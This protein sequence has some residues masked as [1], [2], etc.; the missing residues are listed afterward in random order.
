MAEEERRPLLN[1][2]LRLLVEPT[3]EPAPGGGKSRTTTKVERLEQQMAKLLRQVTSLHEARSTLA[4]HGTRTALL[5]R[6]FASDSLAPSH[7]PT[8]LFSDDVGCRLVAPTGDGYIVEA[9]VARLPELAERIRRA[10][11][12]AIR[13]DI[14][15]VR[16]IRRFDRSGVLRGRSVEELWNRAVEADGGRYFLVWLRPYHDPGAREAL[17]SAFD[18]L[19]RE[20]T[21]LPSADAGPLF[22][23]GPP[24]AI[25]STSTARAMRE[26]RR[27]RG[28][29]RAVVRV[30]DRA[31]LRRILASGTVFRMDP[32]RPVRASAGRGGTP[33]LPVP[34]LP[35]GPVVA[36]VDG[37]LH[38]LAYKA[39]ESWRVAPIVSDTDADRVHGNAVVSLVAHAHELN[40]H[41][42]LPR[43]GT[44]VGT[45]Q[46][47][48]HRESNVLLLPDD[49][50]DML[51]RMAARHRDARV[52]NMSFNM[53]ETDDEPDRVSDLGHQ[54]SRIARAARV[55]PVIS[56][57]NV[58]RGNKRLQPPADCEAALTV[59]GRTPT[60][61]G[62]PG[63]PCP[64]CCVGPGPEG[65]LKP[66]V[67]W[68][69]PMRVAGG[70]EMIG[71]SFPTAPVSTLAAHSFEHLR[72]PTPDLVRAL[73]INRTE[74]E[75]HEAGRGWGTPYDGRPPWEC[76]P[77]TVT[78]LL[79]ATL[80]LGNS[81]YWNDIPIP[82]EMIDGGHLVGGAALTAVLEP[83][84]SPFGGANYFAPRV[85]VGLQFPSRAGK[86]ENLLGTLQ[87]STLPEAVAR[88]ELKK[89]QPVRHYHKHAFKRA[90]G[91]TALRL[92]A[93]L[94]ARDL[95]QPGLPSRAAMPPQEAA[96]VLTLKAHGAG[97]AS[98]Y[99]S[100]VRELGNYVESAVVVQEVQ[101]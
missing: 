4:V 22:E 14:S 85:E 47:V 38:D 67:S 55:L 86:W 87:E 21:L 72:E 92:R 70:K 46:A 62:K 93:R 61:A 27:T 17:L 101:V 83:L 96:I 5:A 23:A 97:S 76:G 98:I 9:D 34:T 89:W 75:Q 95:Y 24:D 31:R 26:Y 32:V 25:P 90:V 41:L 40:P 99:D 13:S 65:M 6:M 91:G 15:R 79:R 63:A 51:Q 37:G 53:E 42:D 36:V 71:S 69:S 78:M 57:G 28:V 73:L 60:R 12:W 45:A 20:R 43:L 44:R 48:P 56:V 16:S 52:W 88:Q 80:E 11:N 59:G 50:L 68:H 30:S 100:V 2:A 94:F 66:D 3:P 1:P 84:V 64:R 58:F 35:P 10:P 39:L 74:L 8:D 82:P 81:Y 33:T 7:S 77:G 54:I 29:G 49:L 18:G 19:A